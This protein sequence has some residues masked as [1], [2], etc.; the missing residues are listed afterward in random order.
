MFAAS[1]C[2][3]PGSSTFN[4]L[5]AQEAGN[6]KIA[7]SYFEEIVNKRNL[8][9]VSKIFSPDYIDHEMDGTENRSIKAG[10]FIPFLQKLFKAFPD[11]HY[12]IES[13]VAEA[14]IVAL[15]L[16]AHATHKD[17][18]LG[19]PA[20]GNKINYKQMHFFRIKDGKIMECWEVV[21]LDGVKSQLKSM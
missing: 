9:L 8:D 2:S 16:S 15:N 6:K 12:T 19:F 21:D 3:G 11:L 20:S 18:F 10:T 17:A 7:I 13:A 4:I 5:S 1:A 14:D